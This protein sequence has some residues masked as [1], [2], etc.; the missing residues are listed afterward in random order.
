MGERGEVLI[1]VIGIILA[2]IL[3]FVFPMAEIAQMNDKEIQA[4]IQSYTIEFVNKIRSTAMIDQDEIDSFYQE[5][6]S[7]GYSFEIEYE[8]HKA[9]SNPGKKTEY[10][11]IGD[12]TYYVMYTPQIQTHLENNGGKMQ[13][14]EGDYIVVY[15]KITSTTMSQMFKSVLYGLTG[16]QAYLIFAQHSGPVLVTV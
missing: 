15:V 4:L 9:D 8:V 10:V 12:T 14:K 7:T 6:Y 5:L 11:D 13:L 1:T 3:M 2:T 16:D